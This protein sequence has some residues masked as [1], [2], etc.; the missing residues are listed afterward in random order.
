MRKIG[1]KPTSMPMPI[2][3]YSVYGMLPQRGLMTGVQVR[4]RD[5]DPRSLGC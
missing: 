3:L 5:P 1:P 2:L 4:A